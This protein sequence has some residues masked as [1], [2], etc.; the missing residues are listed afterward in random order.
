MGVERIVIR[1]GV[2]ADR[3]SFTPEEGELLVTTDRSELFVGD[4]STAG[5]VKLG[6]IPSAP[7]PRAPWYYYASCQSTVAT[8]AAVS[9]NAAIYQP[10]YVSSKISLDRIGVYC[11]SAGT[12]SHKVRVGLYDTAPDGQVPQ[13]LIVNSGELIC[14]TTGRIQATIAVTLEPGLYWTCILGNNATP[15]FSAQNFLGTIPQL[16]NA[17]GTVTFPNTYFQVA[18]YASG[19]PSRAAVLSSLA[20][21]APLV[22]MRAA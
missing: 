5:G 4:G 3:G 14:N 17:A 22:E 9:P 1:R 21:N 11:T 19:L 8:T 12:A 18:L 2:E 13:D 20:A 16:G 10:W 7:A 6:P 15:A